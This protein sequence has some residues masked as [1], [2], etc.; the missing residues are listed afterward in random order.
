MT[1][2]ILQISL[3][4]VANQTS[5][6][7]DSDSSL[8]SFRSIRTLRALRPLRAISRWEG[9]KVTKILKMSTVLT[10]WVCL[11]T[12]LGHASFK[13]FALYW[14]AFV[15]TQETEADFVAISGTEQSCAASITKVESHISDRFCAILWCSEHLL[16]PSRKSI[17][18]SEDWNPLRREQIFRSEDWNLVHQTLSANRRGTMFDVCERLVPP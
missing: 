1:V 13:L 12:T 17:S 18:R 4:S 2:T 3:T 8:S 15:Q 16:G 11:A 7:G 5:T 6:N 14:I 9:M 10:T